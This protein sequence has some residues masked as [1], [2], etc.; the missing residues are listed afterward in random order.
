M[1]TRKKI[2]DRFP[3]L[4]RHKA[5]G[6]SVVRLDG[7]DVYC[8]PFGTAECRARYLRAIADREAAVL[9]RSALAVDDPP[10]GMSDLTINEVM[11]AYRQFADSYYI[12]N[13]RPTTESGNI[14]L[15]IRPLRELYGLTLAREF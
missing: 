1:V 6:Q 7:K 15:A 14:R 5:S 3:K 11:L 2:S 13:G 4:T 12:K 9:D 10:G 8:G